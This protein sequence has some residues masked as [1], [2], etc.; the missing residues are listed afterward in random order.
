MDF[1]VLLL[2]EL[3]AALTERGLSTRI[4]FLI[5]QDLLWPPLEERLENQERFILMFAPISRTYS[6]ELRW[7]KEAEVPPYVRNKLSFPRSAEANVAFLDA[8]REVFAGDSFDFDYHLMYYRRLCG[9]AHARGLKVLMHSCG[10]NWE[11]LAD[12]MDVGI[13]CFHRSAGGL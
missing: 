10:Y 8:W 3:D 13:D 6:R 4:V 9:A 2:N 12:L 7:S 11:L 5:Y 1:Y